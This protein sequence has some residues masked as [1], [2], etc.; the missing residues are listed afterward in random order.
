MKEIK[1]SHPSKSHSSSTGNK[2]KIRMQ[3]KRAL[4]SF[5]PVNVKKFRYKNQRRMK[6][7]SKPKR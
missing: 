4:L 2:N 5:E 1:S 6:E 7:C 3:S